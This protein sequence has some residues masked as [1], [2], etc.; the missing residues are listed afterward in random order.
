MTEL[1][2]AV[3][4]LRAEMLAELPDA[5]VQDDFAELQRI[6]EL[7][8]LERLRRLGEIERRGLWARDGHLSAA[9]W[10]ADRFRVG[11]GAARASMRLARALEH[12]PATR[13]AIEAG[14]VS[15]ASARV[16]MD[17]REGEPEA[18]ATAE[19]TLVE[20]A[21]VHRVHDLVRVTNTWRGRVDA[22]R[23][24]DAEERLRARRR[25]HASRTFSDGAFYF[26]RVRPGHYRLAL[27]KSS[28]SALEIATPPQVDVVVGAD[29]DAIV[30]LPPIAL[31]RDAATSP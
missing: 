6:G 21:R 29:S 1:R 15:L 4:A 16:L 14:D 18:F 26:G 23:G 13:E 11:F 10:L 7:V 3:E 17:A 28:A 30:E 8:E 22:E 27:A 2:S 24:V 5:R 25:L 20:A 9:A 31:E 12:M 19:P